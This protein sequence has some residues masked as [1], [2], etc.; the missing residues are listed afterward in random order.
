MKQEFTRQQVVDEA[1]R[2]YGKAVCTDSIDDALQEDTLQDAA[3]MV[4]L[5]TVMWDSPSG[6]PMDPD[7]WKN[8]SR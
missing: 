4:L 5:E 7:I 3:N 2:R 1:C 6:N 8:I